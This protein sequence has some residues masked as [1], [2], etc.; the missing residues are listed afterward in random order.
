MNTKKSV[1]RGKKTKKTSMRGGCKGCPI[2]NYVF[3]VI[4]AF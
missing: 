1:F 4:L 2:K 3:F